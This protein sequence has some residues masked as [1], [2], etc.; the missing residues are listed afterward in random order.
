MNDQKTYKVLVVCYTYNQEK[1]IEESLKSFVSQKTTFPYFVVVVDDCS[2]DK[3]TTIVKQYESNYPE[4]INGI[5]LPYNY[6]SKGETK[7]KILEEW[8]SR[9]KYEAVCE[10]DDWWMDNLK[11][12]KQH[13]ALEAHPECDMCACGAIVYQNGIEIAKKCPSDNDRIIPVEEVIRGGGGY[14]ATNSLMYRT[15]I[16]NN[17]LN[18][19]R[20]YE[21]DYLVQ[22]N[23][24]L[25]GGIVYLANKMA[26]YRYMAEG[27]FTKAMDKNYLSGFN[28]SLKVVTALQLF[29]YETGNR[30]KEATNEVLKGVVL[31]LYRK[32]LYGGLLDKSIEQIPFGARMKLGLKYI[33]KALFCCMK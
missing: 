20:Y 10:G 18:F 2:T 11:L 12:Q 3:T 13:D 9:A 5:Y 29:D 23:G 8:R 25:R 16:M 17:G 33:S 19:W 24:A 4:L 14:F 28:H 6:Y 21:L 30:Y 32:G 22:I 7:Q 26:A 1:Y 27:S 15:S 31:S